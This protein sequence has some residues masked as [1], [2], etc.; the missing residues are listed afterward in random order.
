MSTVTEV[1]CTA[2]GSNPENLVVM[3]DVVVPLTAAIGGGIVAAVVGYFPARRLAK[4]ASSEL[5]GRDAKGRGEQNARAARQVYV[6]LH[7]LANSIGTYHKQIEAMIGR[8]D[9]DKNSRMRIFERLSTYPGID[10]EPR[11]DFLAEELEIFISTNQPAY[12]DRLLLAS[13]N[14]AACISNLSAFGKLKAEWHDLA[15]L[16]GQTS[17]DENGVSKT[18]M[19]VPVDIA[20]HVTVKG[21][22]LESFA[23]EMRQLISEWNDFVVSVANDYEDA[24][25]SFFKSGERP[26]FESIRTGAETI[27]IMPPIATIPSPPPK[28]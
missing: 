15:T 3:K 19:R 2:M 10:N 20:N 24:T 28:A 23:T 6:K 4:A 12:M 5:L 9:K 21:D 25:V 26:G 13:R 27:T 17:R 22:E 14:H 16:M 18:F 8:A 11:I 1:I 7:M